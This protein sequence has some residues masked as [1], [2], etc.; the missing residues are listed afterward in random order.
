[1]RCSEKG[2]RL[3]RRAYEMSDSEILEMVANCWPIHI[4]KAR[5]GGCYEGGPWVAVVDDDFGEGAF[6]SDPECA[7]YWGHQWVADNP[8]PA[9]HG[10]GQTPMEALAAAIANRSADMGCGDGKENGTRVRG[11]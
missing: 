4:A 2:E 7:E 6:D 9:N 5:Y 1:L 11:D 10:S 3:L 8:F